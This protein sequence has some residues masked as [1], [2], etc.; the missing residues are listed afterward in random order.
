MADGI[1]VVVSA[2]DYAFFAQ[3]VR[4]YAD[5]C[6]DRYRDDSWFVDQA[7]SHQSLDRELDALPRAYGAPK[8]KAFLARRGEEIVG[9]GAY[10]KLSDGICEMKR[11]FVPERFRGEGTG[12]KLCHAIV[13]AARADGFDL[14]RLDTANLLTEAIALYESVGFRRCA[15]YSEYPEKL[16]RYMVFMERPLVAAEA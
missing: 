14:M 8:G 1:F 11:L 2:K 3:L 9:C 7:L 12:R 5:W 15:P 16:M 4:E 10:R 6:R 13:A